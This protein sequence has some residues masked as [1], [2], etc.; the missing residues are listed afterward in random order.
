VGLIWAEGSRKWVVGMRG[1]APVEL[2]WRSAMATRFRPKNGTAELGE[3]WR[4][5]RERWSG[6]GRVESSRGG[7]V[8]LARRATADPLSS[9]CLELEEGEEGRGKR[10]WAM[11]EDKLELE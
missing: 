11:G 8:W 2:Q 1:G 4:R 10:S 9:A 7:G 6:T 3:R 5:W